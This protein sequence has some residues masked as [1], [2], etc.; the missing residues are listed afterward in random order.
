[1]AKK[2][3]IY[4]RRDFVKS[5]FFLLSGAM[6]VPS[7][8][9][10][11]P[12]GDT[13]AFTLKPI[14]RSLSLEDYYIWCSSPIWGDDG[15]VHLFYSR[16]KKEKGMSGW[17]RGS[18]I[19]HAVADGPNATF[20]DHGVVL[21]PREGH[22]DSTTCHNPL[23]QKV[24]DTYYLFYMGNSNGKTNTKRIGIATAKSLNGPWER[25]ESPVLTPGA[26]GAWDDHCT[27]N[28]A[29]VAGDDGKYWLFYKSWN[30]KEYQEASGSVRG[31]RKY[32]LAKADHPLGPYNKVSDEPIIDFS[33]RPNNAQL[34][35][36]FVWKE[37]GTHYMIARDMGFYNHEYGL[38][39]SSVDGLHWSE[40][41]IAYLDMPSYVREDTPPAH[42]K[43]FGRL[44]RPMFLLDKDK[45]TPRY[46]FGATQGGPSDTSTTFVFDIKS[47][48]L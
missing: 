2:V 30:T 40:P 23:I 21:H 31:N 1:M 37:D 17:I 11:S 14:G 48:N 24:G 41:K 3:G 26:E 46:L 47:Y 18:E 34:E 36:A 35:D 44:E 9:A 38:L 22:W 45:G 25:S 15:K 42:L 8:L 5:G 12:A 29:F 16:W 32:G 7:L 39:L 13:P 43:R 6:V 28:P 20:V 4:S 10:F 27:T 19:A 33:G